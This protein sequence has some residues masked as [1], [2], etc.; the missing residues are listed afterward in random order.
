MKPE[1][2]FGFLIMIFIFMLAAAVLGHLWMVT[3][4]LIMFGFEMTWYKLDLILYKI[5]WKDK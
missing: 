4:S 2:P 1:F 5:D 3:I